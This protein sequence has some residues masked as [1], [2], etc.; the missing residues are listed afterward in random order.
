MAFKD[1]IDIIIP[2]VTIP[3]TNY[4][5]HEKITDEKNKKVQQFPNYKKLNGAGILD[6][7]EIKYGTY[8]CTGINSDGESLCDFYQ[9]RKRS[10]GL[11]IHGGVDLGYTGTCRDINYISPYVYS[12]IDGTVIKTGGSENSV[13]ILD[14][15]KKYVHIIRHLFSIEEE[16][17]S[18]KMREN[19]LKIRQSNI[20]QTTKGIEKIMP[21]RFLSTPHFALADVKVSIKRGD[22]VGC[23]GGTG[24]EKLNEYAPHVH[25]EIRKYKED[26]LIDPV[27]FWNN[28]KEEKYFSFINSKT[29]LIKDSG[30]E[31]EKGSGQSETLEGGDNDDI[32]QGFHGNDTLEGGKGFDAYIFGV[33]GSGKN[34]INDGKDTIIDSDGKGQV[35]INS[36]QI[37]LKVEKV[38]ENIYKETIGDLKIDYELKEDKDNKTKKDLIVKYGNGGQITIKDF[39]EN[40]LMIRLQ[41][42]KKEITEENEDDEREHAKVEEARRRKH[43]YIQK[44][45]PSK[46]IGLNICSGAE[47]KCIAGGATC[48]IAGNHG[49]LI[50]SK[51]ISDK[52]IITKDENAKKNIPGFKTCKFKKNDPCTFSPAGEWIGTDK[53]HLIDG[54]ETVIDKSILLCSVGGVITVV[55]PG[56]SDSWYGM[57]P[58]SIKEIEEKT[59]KEIKKAEEKLNPPVTKIDN[60]FVKNNYKLAKKSQIV[61]GHSNEKIYIDIVRVMENDK[62]IFGKLYFDGEL[63]GE[64]AEKKEKGVRTEECRLAGE[65]SVIKDNG[66]FKIIDDNGKLYDGLR[67]EDLTGS[68]IMTGKEWDI[69]NTGYRKLKGKIMSYLMQKVEQQQKELENMNKECTIRI[70]DIESDD[71]NDEKW[72][73]ESSFAIGEG[74]FTFDAEGQEGIITKNSDGSIKSNSINFSRIP[75]C[76]GNSSGVTIGRGYDLK[77]R[78][79]V[80]IRNTMKKLS[81]I[82]GCK[83]MNEEL[84]NWLGKSFKISGQVAKVQIEKMKKNISPEN[85]HISRKQQYFLFKEIYESY[86]KKEAKRLTTTKTIKITTDEYEQ[87]LFWV[88]DII[89]DLRYQGVNNSTTRKAFMPLVQEGV[90]TGD[91]KA[92]KELMN[93]IDYWKKI[94]PYTADR[95]KRRADYC[96]KYYNK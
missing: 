59:A 25:Y 46:K 71:E 41:G 2:P 12:P 28:N 72:L 65:Y 86:Y 78:E 83:P 60:K 39:Y 75:H 51:K 62:Y 76:P 55:D 27:T 89:I 38:S 8:R 24:G 14:S 3:D 17:L 9:T 93:N 10:S 15:D 68:S 67:L 96:N 80:E 87:L 52:E 85:Q 50:S 18:K 43:D 30:S 16:F 21:E 91:F 57:P 36:C 35:I 66:Y 11:R 64:T 1:I 90:K 54:K 42:R 53:G 13:H 95:V 82:Y 32:L 34:S 47:L 73:K 31:I 22:I 23:M 5:K 70:K 48:K 45:D 61:F 19:V 88:K 40:K 77:E 92:F 74:W 20:K 49:V 4:E 69:D 7:R 79:E 26:I 33:L 94:Q 37:G 58:A 63:I 84:I 44:M 81:S 29:K 56:L 6:I